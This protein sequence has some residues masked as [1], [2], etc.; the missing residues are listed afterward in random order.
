MATPSTGFS[1]AD[2]SRSGLSTSALST[3]LL[4]SSSAPPLL[5]AF[6]RKRARKEEHEPLDIDK[7]VKGHAE[8]IFH[9][10]KKFNAS[11]FDSAFQAKLLGSSSREMTLFVARHSSKAPEEQLREAARIGNQSLLEAFIA[12][13]MDLD[14]QDASGQTAVVWASKNGHFD[15]AALLIQAGAKDERGQSKLIRAIQERDPN[16]LTPALVLNPSL[17]NNPD[18]SARTPLMHAV[19]ANYL[20]AVDIL[21]QAKPELELRDNFGLTALLHGIQRGSLAIVLKLIASGAKTE[22]PGLLAVTPLV[23]AS[24]LRD[25]EIVSN[26]LQAGAN[27]AHFTEGGDSALYK[28]LKNNQMANFSLL[29]AALRNA[30]VSL[31]S[32]SSS[33]SSSSFSSSSA[34]SLLPPDLSKD[35]S[36]L[37]ALQNGKKEIA[38]ELAK[39]RIGIFYQNDLY[40]E[41]PLEL[42]VK[43]E[44]FP[45]VEILVQAGVN[46]EE[47]N[48]D[49]QTACVLAHKLGLK[50]IANFL[51]EEGARNFEGQTLITD[52]IEKGDCLALQR[53]LKLFSEKKEML[54]KENG[55]GE[56]P[57]MRAIEKENEE[58]VKLLISAKVNLESRNC[59]GYTPLLKALK[60]EVPTPII[61]MLIEAGA[62]VNAS[63]ISTSVIS[64]Q[65]TP[66]HFAVEHLNKPE[67]LEKLLLK[68][69]NTEATNPEG[70]TALIL[71][72]QSFRR[73]SNFTAQE[74]ILRCL[75]AHGAKINAQRLKGGT[76][77]FF[78]V[79]NKHESLVNLL[80]KA[81]AALNLKTING[82]SAIGLAEK[83]NFASIRDMLWKAGA[84]DPQRDPYLM[85]QVGEGN[86][87]VVKELIARGFDLDV[88]DS[89]GR[90]A[91]SIAVEEDFLEILAL[92][93][94]AGAKPNIQDK[95][96]CSPLLLAA[97]K[98]RDQSI[99]LLKHKANCKIRTYDGATALHLAAYFGYNSTLA[100]LMPLGLDLD[101][102]NKNRQTALQVAKLAGH[103]STVQMLMEAGARDENGH[104][105]LMRA[106]QTGDMKT[107]RELIAKEG[108]DL[109]AVVD[110]RPK[111]SALTFCTMALNVEGLIELAK[112]GANLH[113][114]NNCH[115]SWTLSALALQEIPATEKYLAL[116]KFFFGEFYA[117]WI[118]LLPT[119]RAMRAISLSRTSAEQFIVALMSKIPVDFHYHLLKI[120]FLIDLPI[121]KEAVFLKLSQENIE[122]GFEMLQKEFPNSK[123]RYN[124]LRE[125]DLVFLP[126]HF[127][128]GVGEESIPS[129]PQVDLEG[130]S[131]LFKKINVSHSEL[132]G[133]AHP[134]ALKNDDGS[135]ITIHEAATHLSTYVRRIKTKEPF[136]GTPR[137]G[138]TDLTDYYTRL[139]NMASH[140]L[141]K[142][143][144]KTF[145]PDNRTSLLIDLAI[146]G[147]H[148]GIRYKSESYTWYQRVVMK[149][150]IDA[151]TV[152]EKLMSILKGF[153]LDILSK[154]VLSQIDT[155][156]HLIALPNLPHINNQ[157]LIL[158]GKEYGLAGYENVQAD[159]A[160]HLDCLTR[161]I[162]IK[163]FSELYTPQTV[164][165]HIQALLSDS[166]SSS[167][168]RDEL[169]YW[170]EAEIPSHQAI[171]GWKKWE[172]STYTA[173]T[174][175]ISEKIEKS[176]HFLEGFSSEERVNFV[177]Q[178]INLSIKQIFSNYKLKL[179]VEGSYSQEA[180]EKL[181][182]AYP[183]LKETQRQ[184]IKQEIRQKLLAFEDPEYL[185]HLLIVEIL[186]EDDIPV[187][188]SK[189][190]RKDLADH[191]LQHFMGKEIY[192][193]ESLGFKRSAIE[194][195]L[196]VLKVLH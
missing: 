110:R 114:T 46:L 47:K 130:F 11:I 185:K 73:T 37:C 171:F 100:A 102:Q 101:A 124:D 143:Q 89:D 74:N 77:L 109:N 41:T 174:R 141:L 53:A 71:A 103:E 173:L 160:F 120:P 181:I 149:A 155:E 9:H 1:R 182:D 3:L 158:I 26:L 156:G 177:N 88:Q 112:A 67:I 190:W 85:T 136:L 161:E 35:R 96:G 40:Q 196:R 104:T 60:D 145:D 165:G 83:L 191:C 82:K 20:E 192:E 163:N 52:A 75:L 140:L 127:L 34:L 63:L 28:A 152:P 62:G 195:M 123:L 92:L 32:S 125:R 166:L 93:L 132:P 21:L 2:F 50:K 164:I 90:C 121:I 80:I 55:Q 76:A 22:T 144:E 187:K 72:A 194:K 27:I 78:A 146:A 31:N 36:L 175:K 45:V 117:G 64:R 180:T 133:Y 61:L 115:F 148:C 138:S 118:E 87:T 69:A 189:N 17:L 25:S 30:P 84:N 193:T 70:A 6:D 154:L 162:A 135:Q 151:L 184:K 24:G 168:S 58:M 159:P 167:L 95:D 91:L 65:T 128:H 7:R 14:G 119:P 169:T 57:L 56:K 68:G 42:A 188:D 178:R 19:Q 39:R 23:L 86:V 94:A 98:G 176:M 157:Y 105:P 16:L 79:R 66:L 13:G 170:F 172:E 134:R 147:S 183:D 99:E 18:A 8:E 142:A 48:M 12:S 38:L 108:T 33:S 153:R 129:A 106:I 97:L 29:M 150:S 179:S 54:E 51:F 49:G 131:A 59:S 15:S 116:I 5:L 137:E 4:P 44:L 10:Q 111:V 43:E 81:G 126:E 122:R 186:D 107:F 113:F 139:T